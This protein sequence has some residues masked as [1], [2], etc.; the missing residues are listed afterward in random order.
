MTAH[1]IARL[2]HLGD[3]ITENGLFAPFTLPGEEVEGAVSAGRI[4]EPRILT[5]SGNR[6]KAPCPHFRACGGCALQHASDDFVANW[7]VEVVETALKAQGLQATFLP[8]AVSPPGA[9]RRAV[10]AGKRTKKGAMVG[11]HGRASDTIIA[12]PGCTLLHPAILAAIPALEGLTVLGAS[13][14]AVL[15]LSVTHS[16]GGLD[17]AVENGRPVD[18]PLLAQLG[19]FCAS[20]GFARLAWNGEVIATI[21]PPVQSFG[22]ARVVP[23]PGGFLQATAHGQ[24]ALT[25]GVQAA[26]DGA[27]RVVDL[28]AGSGTFALALADRAEIHAVESDAAALAALDR[29][30][31]QSPGLKVITCETRD[32]FRRPLLADELA[33]FDG[34]VIDPPRAGAEAQMRLLAQSQVPRIAVVSCNPVTFARDASILAAGGYALERIQVVDQFRWSVHIELV[35][36]FVR[37]H[38]G[39]A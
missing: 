4:A 3:G 34:V 22:R 30:W 25:A 39:S 14:K 38:I 27:T 15:A 5:P 26:L 21:N 31:R 13:R 20:A 23:P 37:C 29:G 17:L 28:F 1:R 19:A 12:I 2:G 16:E 32:L 24:A 6:V 35:A 7:K 18:G 36:G 33:R 8:I 11:L 9:R 10:L